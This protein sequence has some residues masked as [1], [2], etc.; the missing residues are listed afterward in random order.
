[1]LTIL[2]ALFLHQPQTTAVAAPTQLPLLDFQQLCQEL[3]LQAGASLALVEFSSPDGSVMSSSGVV[4]D[5]IGHLIVPSRIK[6]SQIDGNDLVIT[7]VR[8]DGKSF[9]ASLIAENA[10]YGLSLLHAPQLKGLGAKPLRVLRPLVPG[11]LAFTYSNFLGSLPSLSQAMISSQSFRYN[12][13][14]LQPLS[15]RLANNDVGMVMNLEGELMGIVWPDFNAPELQQSA[16]SFF[17]PVEVVF[18]IFGELTPPWLSPRVLG[19]HVEQDLLVES[20]Q[21][22]NC[23]W[24]LTVASVADGSVAHTAG[25]L[26]GD[27][28]V[29]L[30]KVPLMSVM[31]LRLVLQGAPEKSELSISRGGEKQ[32]LALLFS[33]QE[34]AK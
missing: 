31:H 32:T 2:L 3:H 29:A 26:P 18:D 17:V 5:D 14:L 20:S 34:K 19:V 11:A 28:L 25:L 22:G 6:M 21:D 23:C 1:M 12:G 33:A 27:E 15:T 24:R 8:A 13:C 16:M 4:V 9:S 7:V 30:N 10:S